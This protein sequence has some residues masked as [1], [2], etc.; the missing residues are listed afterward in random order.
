MAGEASIVVS[1]LDQII[2]G[3]RALPS[4]VNSDVRNRLTPVL[5]D[6]KGRLAIY[7]PERIHQKYRRT[8]NLGRGW[9]NAQER[10]VVRSGGGI[11]LTLQNNVDYVDQVQGDDQSVYFIGRWETASAVLTSYEGDITIAVEDGCLDAMRRMGLL[12]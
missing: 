9:T 1:G 11:D 2:A 12:P 7:P 6:M 8:G 10:Y 5:R 3:F 4:Q